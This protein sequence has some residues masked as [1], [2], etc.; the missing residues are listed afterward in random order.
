[1]I[2]LY[3]LYLFSSKSTLATNISCICNYKPLVIISTTT[4]R[5]YKVP[6]KIVTSIVTKMV[7]LDKITNA[8]VEMDRIPCSDLWKVQHALLFQVARLLDLHEQEALGPLH[9]RENLLED[10]LGA[11]AFPCQLVIIMKDT[12]SHHNF[13]SLINMCID[14]MQDF[15]HIFKNSKN[16]FNVNYTNIH[17]LVEH[18]FIQIAINQLETMQKVILT[19]ISCISK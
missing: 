2:L 17:V 7:D 11:G 4:S 18:D 15:P 5:F 8:W 13:G 12:T 1:M 9:H 19:C 3:I 16:I 6:G 10:L 14:L